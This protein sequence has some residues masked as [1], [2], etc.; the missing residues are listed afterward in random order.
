MLDTPDTIEEQER[1]RGTAG[2]F[3]TE[4]QRQN[5]IFDKLWVQQRQ[6]FT[7]AVCIYQIVDTDLSPMRCQI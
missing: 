1:L 4:A 2:L 3:P 6:D 5:I 7:P